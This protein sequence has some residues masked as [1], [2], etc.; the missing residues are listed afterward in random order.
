M[1]NL[2]IMR[3]LYYTFITLLRG[4]SANVVKFVSLTLGLLVGVLLFS[5]IVYELN[6]D[7]C[8]EEHERLAMFGTRNISAKGEIGDWEYDSFRPAAAA[9]AESLPDWVECA[10]PIYFWESPDIY[11]SAQDDNKLDDVQAI[12]VDTLYFRTMGINVLSGDP[13]S[14][15]TACNAFISRSMAQRMFG[16]QDVIG[17]TFNWY[18]RDEITVRGVY[19]DLPGNV[20]F[21][22]NIVLSL[23]TIERLYGQGTWDQNDIYMIY[24]RLHRA[25][26][27]EEVNRR[28]TEVVS[29]YTP[30]KDRWDG[31]SMECQI[32]P[33][34]DFRWTT[35]DNVRRLVILFVL[36]FSI[37]FVSGMNYVLAAI[38][39]IGRRAKMVG[40]HKCCGADAGRVMGFFLWETGIM[41]LAAVV[42]SLLLMNLFHDLIEDM[43]GLS[44]I[45]QLFTWQTLW[46]PVLT[47]VVLFLVAGVLPGQ[48]FARIPVTQVFRRY[49]DDKRSWKRGLLFVQFMGVAFILG[50]LITSIWQYRDLTTRS[51]GFDADHLAVG[52]ATAGLGDPGTEEFISTV[53]GIADHLA[54]QPFVETVG[55]SENNLLMYYSSCPVAAEGGS[56]WVHTHFQYFAK[57]FPQAVGM[58]LVEGRF[59]EQEGEALVCEQL[60][61]ELNWGDQAIGRELN[62]I[63]A[64]RGGGSKGYARV[65]GV[66]RDIRNMGF[67]QGQTNVAFI[68]C[69]ALAATFHVRL[70]DPQRENL[71]RLNDLVR[72][73]YPNNGL[74]FLHYA[75]VRR[76]QNR[77][78]LRFRNTVY[79]TSACI[80]LIVLMG[81]IGY[82]ADETQRRSKEIAVRK[83]NGAEASDILQLLS[84]GI[85]KVSVGAVLIGIACAYYVSG[86]W[87]EQFS[88][89]TM[90]SSLWFLTLGVCLLVL[91][92][93][94]VVI[95]AWKIANENPVLSIKSE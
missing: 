2:F 90:L 73:T 51:V 81:L 61:R 43:L 15:A 37:F 11:L 52:D 55:I 80:L 13:K 58:E 69:P 50:M 53:Q 17:K 63:P 65:V 49:T 85:L 62:P 34:T 41:M 60:V 31:S 39:T 56:K 8:Y 29:H 79:M 72:E 25:E 20:S 89:C 19:E 46:V 91:I 7:T 30:V 68:C 14:L 33:A 38:A 94:V 78:V 64:K 21:P 92:V 23:P 32:I 18:K 75:D 88:D 93:L 6:Y 42:G 74:A 27:M 70:K 44:D 36:G 4:K 59:P 22:A 24:V 83:V 45:A 10:T 86:L 66:V 48:M 1:K 57:G 26:D 71:F 87:M 77:D 9:L 67:F 28:I 47:V 5:Q 35:D 16:T 40:V 84:K 54:R 3:Q 95:R 76:D 82:V 12:Y